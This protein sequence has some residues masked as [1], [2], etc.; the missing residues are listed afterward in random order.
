MG[1]RSAVGGELTPKWFEDRAKLSIDIQKR[2]LEVGIEPIHQM[3]IGYFPYKE[4]S[5]VN[6]I[7]GGYWS[8]IKGPFVS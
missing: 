3:F 5:G 4:N 8:K 2:M 1:K 6:V 7:N